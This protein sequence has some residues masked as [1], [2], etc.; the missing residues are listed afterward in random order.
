MSRRIT[1]FVLAAAA[2]LIVT[3]AR[4]DRE[5]FENSCRLPDVIE[6][7]PPVPA[8]AAEDSQ[9][10]AYRSAPEPVPEPVVHR[11]PNPVRH[12]KKAAPREPV[13]L[14]PAYPKTQPAPV[15][16]LPVRAA[17]LPSTPRPERVPAAERAYAAN[18]GGTGGAL[19]LN[20]PA[21]GY[22]TDGIAA[23][24]PYIFY[25]ESHAPRLYVLAPNAKI[26]SIDDGD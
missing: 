18:R 11:E 16:A 12:V 5:C 24:R 10:A 25:N 22:P 19:I 14:A 7:P 13:L 17:V 9:A 1:V 2:A 23:V 26:I 20:V 21:A 8:P 4:A 15:A 3:E 6:P